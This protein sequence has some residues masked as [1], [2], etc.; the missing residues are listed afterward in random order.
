MLGCRLQ[1]GADRIGCGK[2]GFGLLLSIARVA[3][4]LAARLPLSQSG[5]LRLAG[6]KLVNLELGHSVHQK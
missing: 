6:C 3:F 5:E 4:V 2:R 1:T